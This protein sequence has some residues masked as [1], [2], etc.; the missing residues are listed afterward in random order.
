MS[1]TAPNTLLEYLLK[2]DNFSDHI[3]N[4]AMWVNDGEN[5]IRVKYDKL[6]EI[7]KLLL[8]EQEQTSD[9]VEVER[10]R[11][12]RDQFWWKREEVVDLVEPAR[13]NL[14]NDPRL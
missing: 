13:F 1:K 12:W 8:D 9:P 14:I 10:L 11:K 4:R 6:T 2:D 7:I 5:D 3:L